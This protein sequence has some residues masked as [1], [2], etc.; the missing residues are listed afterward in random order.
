M[1][2]GTTA[3]WAIAGLGLFVLGSGCEKKQKVEELPNVKLDLPD[4]PKFEETSATNSD[5]SLTVTELRRHGKKYEKKNVTVRGFVVWAYVCPKEIW[6]CRSTKE[7][8]CT[9]CERPH[10]Y[11]AD[12]PNDPPEKS[13][14]IVDYSRKMREWEA[15]PAPNENCDYFSTNKV[16]PPI[17]AVIGQE[18]T[19][20]GQFN[21]ESL[22]GFRNSRGLLIWCNQ[23]AVGGVMPDPNAPTGKGK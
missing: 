16:P 19:V 5:G 10:Y 12:S 21:Y 20:T 4:P 11:L 23:T 7:K 8:L 14:W 13:I 3:L 2:R 15:D 17:E 22:S 6:E 1:T 9:P 18:V